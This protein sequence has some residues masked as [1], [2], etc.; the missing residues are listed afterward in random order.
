MFIE[1][2]IKFEFRGV[3]PLGRICTSA[4]GYFYYKTKNSKENLQVEYHLAYC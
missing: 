3:A 2:T 1:Q 4:T